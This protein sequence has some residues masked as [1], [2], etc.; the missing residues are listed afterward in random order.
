MAG[1]IGH[2]V[3]TTLCPPD[4]LRDVSQHSLVDVLVPQLCHYQRADV[5]G[6][7]LVAKVSWTSRPRSVEQ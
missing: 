2:C 3:Q 6:I 7:M 5:L 4:A 1:R